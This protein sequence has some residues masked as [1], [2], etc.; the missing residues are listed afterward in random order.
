MKQSIGKYI[1]HSSSEVV[2]AAMAL[3]LSLHHWQPI[4]ANDFVDRLRHCDSGDAEKRARHARIADILDGAHVALA[5]VS[6]DTECKACATQ[7]PE[8]VHTCGGGGSK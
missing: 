3:F 5:S 8:A 4:L 6:D 1:V 7:D 2:D